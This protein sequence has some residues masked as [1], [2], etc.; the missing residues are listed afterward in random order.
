MQP[1]ALVARVDRSR[2]WVL[3]D[4]LLV[5]SVVVAL[6]FEPNFAHGFI[7]Y[8]ES[9]QYL[10]AIDELLRGGVLYRD[11]FAQYGPLQYWIPAGLFASFGPSLSVLRGVLHAGEILSLVSAAALCR[12]VISSRLR[13]RRI[14]P[15]PS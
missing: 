14:H 7:N 9:G 13:P 15:L 6:A 3:F 11:A 10:G 12:V 8:S 4:W 5:P 2:A 1:A